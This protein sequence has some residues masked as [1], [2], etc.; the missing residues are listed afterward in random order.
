MEYLD[1][2]TLSFDADYEVDDTFDNDKYIRLR[3]RVMHDKVNPNKSSFTL[4]AIDKAKE[5]IK[6]IPILAH[7]VE[8]EDG[9][10]DFGG[11][12]F[13]I[14]S[15]KMNDDSYR[16]I[17]QEVPI[18]LV[19]ETND[20]CVAEYNDKNYVYVYGYVYRGYANYSEDIILR[21]KSIKISME[22]LVD[23]Y[24]YNNLTG[25][26]EILEYRYKGITLLGKKYGTGMELAEAKVFEFS[27]NSKVLE[28]SHELENEISKF[29]VNHSLLKESDIDFEKKEDDD[30]D[31]KL[32]L[33]EDYNVK[34]ES[35]DFNIDDISIE[36]LKVKLDE[37]NTKAEEENERQFALIQQF[38][39]ELIE[40]LSVEKIVKEWG[41]Y[42]K[43][44]YV[45]HDDEKQEVYFWNREDWKLYGASF[46]KSGDTVEIDFNTVKRFKFAIEPFDDGIRS[47]FSFN[48]VKQVFECMENGFVEKVNAIENDFNEY[49]TNYATPESEV[50]E[51]KSFKENRLAEDFENKVQEVFSIFEDKLGKVED[52]ITLKSNYQG[53]SVDEVQKECYTILGIH[54]ATFSNK[55]NNSSLKLPIN[56]PNR[57]EAVYGGIFAVHGVKP[58]KQ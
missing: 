23:R 30:L 41:E 29:N 24:E 42:P 53:M 50:V 4:D 18:G 44:A 51:L 27:D 14:E 3:M 11:H 17:Y 37:Y 22:I 5:S 2:K 28:M 54:S 49:K 9:N 19:P 55:P 32:K 58:I 25:I 45:D 34:V 47:E 57:D 12:D 7:V 6:N 16:I 40:K 31:E 43:Y 26:A 48:A 36:D 39:E 35:L 56:T 46:A 1:L 15:D 10:L 13:N 52:F 20:Y 8:D 38:I 21:D 33:L